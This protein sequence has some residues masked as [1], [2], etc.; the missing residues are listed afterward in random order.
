[1]TLSKINAW[2]AMPACQM[3]VVQEDED[4]EHGHHHNDARG[5]EPS[6][7]TTVKNAY[8]GQMLRMEFSLNP[9][10]KA[11]GFLVKNCTIYDR[12]TGSRYVI[13]DS[14]GCSVDINILGHPHYD[15]YQDLALVHWHAF[16][17]PEDATLSFQCEC[18]ICTDIKDDNGQ[19]GCETIPTPPI[20]PEIVTSPQ[21]QQ[22]NSIEQNQVDE[23]TTIES[24]VH[25]KRFVR[26][27]AV[28]TSICL[29]D[30]ENCALNFTVPTIF[31]ATCIG[32]CTINR[33]TPS[34]VQECLVQD[35]S[36]FGNRNCVGNEEQ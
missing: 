18:V 35:C 27:T 33:N 15:T 32:E 29:S 24:F 34:L 20:C 1:M 16:R 31:H 2:A 14:K 25:K 5:Y 23:K 3:R 8:I 10:S 12:T 21:L 11:F 30:Q 13:L 28:R 19:N 22:F 9:P 7:G 26:E 17:I 36:F 6:N 4:S